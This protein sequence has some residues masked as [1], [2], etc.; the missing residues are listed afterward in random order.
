MSAVMLSTQFNSWQ[1]PGA[2]K[3][4]TLSQFQ[5]AVKVENVYISSV[6]EHKTGIGGAARLMFDRDLYA[7]VLRYLICLTSDGQR[8]GKN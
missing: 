1:R 4:L 8:G 2:V 6:T 5:S 7:K 3:N